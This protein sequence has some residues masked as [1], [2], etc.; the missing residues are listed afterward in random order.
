MTRESQF[1]K[2]VR[3]PDGVITV[4]MDVLMYLCRNARQDEIEQYEALMGPWDPSEAAAWMWDQGAIR[5]AGATPEGEPVAAGGWRTIIP[6]VYQS[7]MVG[8]QKGWDHHWPLI[9]RTTRWLMTQLEDQGGARRFQTSALVTRTKACEWYE[10][11]GMKR[12]GTMEGY[13][14][15]GEA[16]ALYGRV[17]RGED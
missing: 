6:G 17:V 3:K 11:L 1:N 7:W 12:E 8:T 2:T 5:I 13:G 4:T 15:G 10:R 16:I 9:H 14:Y